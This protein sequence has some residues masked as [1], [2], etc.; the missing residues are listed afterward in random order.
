MIETHAVENNY[1]YERKFMVEDLN[2]S[3][4]VEIIKSHPSFFDEEYPP[5]QINNIYLDT[6]QYEFYSDNKKGIALRKKARIRWYGS[7]FGEIKKP[8]LEIKLKSGLV[9]DKWSYSLKPF[10]LDPSKIDPRM[11][12]KLFRESDLP[13]QIRED[14]LCL[15]PALLNTYKRTYFNTLERGYRV[16]IDSDLNYYNPSSHRFIDRA[17]APQSCHIVELKHSVESA[18]QADRISRKFPFRLTKSSK[19][20][21]GIDLLNP[22]EF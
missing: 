19:Y 11:F 12:E 9:G 2:K 21:D 18:N 5:R 20:V 4:I 10:T 14:M 6:P 22:M 3:E 1:R 8:V 16:T 15:R 17:S 13:G 7:V